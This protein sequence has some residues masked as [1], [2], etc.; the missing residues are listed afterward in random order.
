[1]EVKITSATA[2]APHATQEC[3]QATIQFPKSMFC[4]S[5]TDFH[6]R[7]QGMLSVSAQQ[8]K[9]W[10]PHLTQGE[11]DVACARR[12]VNH[13]VVQGAPVC[14]SQKLLYDTCSAKHNQLGSDIAQAHT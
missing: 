13:Q 12:E 1:M 11:L 5:F 7:S 6:G 9:G 4:M 14:G 10:G 8:V 3:E 2:P